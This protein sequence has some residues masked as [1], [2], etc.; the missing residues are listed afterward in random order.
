[1]TEGAWDPRLSGPPPLT[2]NTPPHPGL[3]W[4]AAGG[5]SAVSRQ[6]EPWKLHFPPPGL[7]ALG[8]L[9]CLSGL[10]PEVLVKGDFCSAGV[11]RSLECCVCWGGGHPAWPLLC[12]AGTGEARHLRWQ[13]ALL[14][15][16]GCQAGQGGRLSSHLHPWFENPQGRYNRQLPRL[17]GEEEWS[18]ESLQEAGVPPQSFH[19]P[20]SPSLGPHPESVFLSSQLPAR[21]P[22]PQA[23]GS[24]LCN[25]TP[26][27]CWSLRGEIRAC[28]QTSGDSR[29][30]PA[31]RSHGLGGQVSESDLGREAAGDCRPSA[32]SGL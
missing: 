2:K 24:G 6:A 25:P 18:G 9:R 29:L 3:P 16:R 5:Q 27:L 17:T 23:A 1:M 32:W 15:S 14:V 22:R 13:E 7:G 28:P 4:G 26:G 19:G 8:E 11:W 30:R 20:L 10:S 31:R 12:A 21:T